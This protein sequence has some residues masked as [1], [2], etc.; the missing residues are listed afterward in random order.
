MVVHQNKLQSKTFTI[1][2]S[3]TTTYSFGLVFAFI[4]GLAIK[5]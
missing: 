5:K 3:N 1:I 4:T 2:T